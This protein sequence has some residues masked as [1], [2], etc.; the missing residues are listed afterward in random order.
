MNGIKFSRS[1]CPQ[2]KRKTMRT[3]EQQNYGKEKQIHVT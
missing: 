3:T 2:E 1:T